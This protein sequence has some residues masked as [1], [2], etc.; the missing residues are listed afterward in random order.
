ME[1]K[2]S[3]FFLWILNNQSWHRVVSQPAGRVFR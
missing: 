3:S 1:N 2:I